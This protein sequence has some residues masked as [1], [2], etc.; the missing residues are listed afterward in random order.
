MPR[1]APGACCREAARRR[2][3]GRCDRPWQPYRQT[4]KA[5]ALATIRFETSPAGRCKSLRPAPRRFRRR[6]DQAFVFVATPVTRAASC[7]GLA[8][9]EA[10]AV[11][12]LESAFLPSDRVPE[13]CRWT[14]R[15]LVARHD[16]AGRS[17]RLNVKLV[18]FAGVAA[19][20]RHAT[21]KLLRAS[22]HSRAKTMPADARSRYA[23][24]WS[25]P[26]PGAQ[27]CH[28]VFPARSHCQWSHQ[29]R[30]TSGPV[31]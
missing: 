1:S 22:L 29:H 4:L 21:G 6:Q 14:N 8:P 23:G 31:H 10:G 24:V 3:S 25:E 11:R 19:E 15:A 13:A 5:E 18:A 7:S 30:V 12:W 20:Q 28:D 27:N 2:A 17:V 26:A 16:A 9:R